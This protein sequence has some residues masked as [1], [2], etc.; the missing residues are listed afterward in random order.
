MWHRPDVI[1]PYAARGP[2]R[3][4]PAAA[5]ARTR[6]GEDPGLR[7]AYEEA[8]D[9][10]TA[11]F[12]TAGETL[13]AV[14]DWTFLMGPDVILGANSLM[15]AWLM[16]RARPVPRFIAV[17]GLADGGAICMSATAVMSGLYEQIS[18]AG[19]VAAIPVFAWDVCLAVRLIAKGFEPAAL[20][21]RESEGESRVTPH[22]ATGHAPSRARRL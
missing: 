14:H 16:F 1:E 22:A 18:V 4:T 7:N 20:L 2:Q 11:S 19:S 10:D 21:H 8:A 6:P 5:A 15:P 3:T 17:L 13:V 9:S 12:V